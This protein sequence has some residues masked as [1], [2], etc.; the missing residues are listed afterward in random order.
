MFVIINT[1]VQNEIMLLFFAFFNNLK[2]IHFHKNFNQK[3]YERVFFLLL[4]KNV[5]YIFNINMFVMYCQ[6]NFNIVLY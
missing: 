1:Y 3:L 2:K 5:Q 6:K 4:L